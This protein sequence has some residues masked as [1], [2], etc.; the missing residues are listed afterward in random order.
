M[1]RHGG[2]TRRSASRRVAGPRAAAGAAAVWWAVACGA[3]TLRDTTTA[4][5]PPSI[6]P[7]GP[8]PARSDSAAGRLNVRWHVPVAVT[9]IAD[10]RVGAD[11]TQAYASFGGDVRAYDLA[12]GV[13]RWR[14]RGFVGLPRAVVSDGALVIFA[15]G[16]NGTGSL[17]ALDP[18]TGGVRW[19]AAPPDYVGFA[20]PVLDAAHVYVGTSV[21]GGGV[22][23]AVY[24]H[25][26]ATGQVV[27]TATVGADWPYRSSVRGLTLAGGTLYA[28]ATQCLINACGDAVS[29]VIALDPATGA[30][31]WRLRLSDPSR[32][33]TLLVDPVTA[34]RGLL[35]ASDYGGNS[36]WGVDP[37]A[38]R[39]VWRTAF[40]PGWTG[41]AAAPA[42][43]STGMVYVGSG[44]TYAYALDAATGAVRWRT[45]LHGSINELTLCGQHVVAQLQGLF[46]LRA[47]D[48]QVVDSGYVQPVTAVSNLAVSQGLVVVGT[49]DGVAAVVCP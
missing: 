27:W 10:P 15:G 35:F 33:Q 48:G 38:R 7:T 12:T 9:G 39:V 23:V 18:A 42:L 19:T 8:S 4:V 1:P 43:D 2:T 47:N 25:D 32:R 41:P 37:G 34:A 13:V 28:A 14:T 16:M 17:A 26:R 40:T 11:R 29:W 44:D 36:A 30:E 20:A 22:R 46:I 3:P 49:S 45:V 6:Q 24:A 21:M 31:R 5:D